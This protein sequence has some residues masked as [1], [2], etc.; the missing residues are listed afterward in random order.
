MLDK[1]YKLFIQGD[2]QKALECFNKILEMDPDHVKAWNNKGMVLSELKNYDEALKCFDM[3]LK[4]D[5]SYLNS[6]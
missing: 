3:A 6:I 2:H 1:G 4:L 5:P